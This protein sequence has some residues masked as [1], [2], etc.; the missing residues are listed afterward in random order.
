MDAPE[1]ELAST[2]AAM[3]TAERALP[4]AALP[5]AEDVKLPAHIHALLHVIAWC[6]QRVDKVCV[7]GLL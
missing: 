7:C 4:S 6:R 2:H 1:P 5:T 3:P